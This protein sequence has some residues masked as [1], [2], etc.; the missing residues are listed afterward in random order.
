MLSLSPIYRE[1]KKLVQGLMAS[2]RVGIKI[3]TIYFLKIIK[4]SLPLI[5]VPQ[6]PECSPGYFSS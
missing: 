1:V 2:H 6:V 4:V 3:Q 5:S